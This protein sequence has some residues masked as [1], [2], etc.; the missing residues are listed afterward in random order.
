MAIMPEKHTCGPAMVEMGG[1]DGRV[2][3]GAL[4]AVVLGLPEVRVKMV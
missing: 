2:A 4:E 1:P 3:T